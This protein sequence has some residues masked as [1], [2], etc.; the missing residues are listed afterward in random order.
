MNKQWSLFSIGLTPVELSWAESWTKCVDPM[1]ELLL[2]LDAISEKGR[3]IYEW[4]EINP[5]LL[6][7]DLLRTRLNEPGKWTFWRFG[8][9]ISINIQ[10]WCLLSNVTSRGRQKLHLPELLMECRLG[11]SRFNH[12]IPFHY[13]FASLVNM[14][15]HHIFLRVH[16]IRVESIVVKEDLFDHF[17]HSHSILSIIVDNDS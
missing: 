8:I 6:D 1:L 13:Y 4:N 9:S 17:I 14:I 5:I 16:T 15:H 2:D 12:S 7:I 10:Y 11:R 3:N